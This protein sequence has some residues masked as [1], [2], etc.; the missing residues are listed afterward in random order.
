LGPVKGSNT[1]IVQK[2]KLPPSTS[3]FLNLV[4][5]VFESILTSSDPRYRTK[6]YDKSLKGLELRIQNFRAT[7]I[8]DSP[9]KPGDIKSLMPKQNETEL[10]ML[11]LLVYLERTARNFSGHSAKLTSYVDEAFEVLSRLETCISPFPLL[12]LG[13]EARSEERRMIILELMDDIDTQSQSLQG[14]SRMLQAIWTQDD[15]ATEREL[16]YAM[17]LDT[18]ISSYPIMPTFA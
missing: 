2:H 3:K 4:Y 1:E 12:I 11:S 8:I 18:V 10:Y 15:L 7:K 9:T 5:D 13:C 14:V 6:E 16:D 17:K